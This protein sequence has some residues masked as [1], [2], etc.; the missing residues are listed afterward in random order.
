MHREHREQRKR[1]K[2]EGEKYVQPRKV[3]KGGEKSGEM[4]RLGGSERRR[5][6]DGA[7]GG[8]GEA[9]R[10]HPAAGVRPLWRTAAQKE[11]RAGGARTAGT[12]GPKG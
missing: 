8:Q 11:C 9:G 12:R 2:G 1:D 6:K 7:Q 4:M 10:G 5:A 3:T